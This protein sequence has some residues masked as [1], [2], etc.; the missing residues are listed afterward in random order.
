MVTV[1][2]FA[3]LTLAS[4]R[5]TRLI[6]TDKITNPF[7]QSI[8]K[9]SGTEGWWTYLVHCP[10][11]MSVWVTAFA[12]VYWVLASGISLVYLLPGWWAM[13]YLVAPILVKFDQED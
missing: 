5:V 11:C 3:L 6:V 12:S 13:S 1:G 10:F 4:A 8:V 7:R 9:K 2:L